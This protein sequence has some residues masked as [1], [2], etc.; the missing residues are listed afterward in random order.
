ME[1]ENLNSKPPNAADGSDTRHL[2]SK[3]EDAEIAMARTEEDSFS[4][5]GPG[6]G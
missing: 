5:S 1:G 3:A 6:S 4:P 2:Q